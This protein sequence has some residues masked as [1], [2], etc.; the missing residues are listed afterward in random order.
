M[1][2]SLKDVPLAIR[3]FYYEDNG[4]VLLKPFGLMKNLDE[5]LTEL[6]K[7]IS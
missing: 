2:E 1:F 4:A 7:V 5:I 6:P 3:D